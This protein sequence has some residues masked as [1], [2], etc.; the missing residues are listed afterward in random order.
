MDET[1]LSRGINI[2]LILY[3]DIETV[4]LCL[5]TFFLSRCKRSTCYRS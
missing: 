1:P 3:S 4:L 2:V 5:Q